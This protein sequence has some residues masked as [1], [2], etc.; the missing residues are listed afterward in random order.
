M[1]VG[2][3]EDRGGDWR[4]RTATNHGRRQPA[5]IGFGQAAAVGIADGRAD[6]QFWLDLTD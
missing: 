1:V 6:E 4:A 5:P 2:G 3:G